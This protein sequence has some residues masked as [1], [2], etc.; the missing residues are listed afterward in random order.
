MKRIYM[1][2]EQRAEARE[3]EG[4]ARKLQLAQDEAAMQIGLKQAEAERS[5]QLQRAGMAKDEADARSKAEVGAYEFEKT[6]G[7]SENKLLAE[8]MTELGRSE[9]AS[10]SAAIEQW[11][12]LSDAATEEDV[13]TRNAL[14]SQIN[15]M[16]GNL[17]QS[18]GQLRSK[19]KID[20]T[21]KNKDPLE[22]GV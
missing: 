2:K 16:L 9:R 20:S 21:E 5:I 1:T 10:L 4:L 12:S 11:K 19:F 22:L 13:A 17:E 15:S 8:V 14:R 3:E 7:L 18:R 6:F